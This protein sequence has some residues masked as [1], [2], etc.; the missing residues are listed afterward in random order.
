MDFL[1][2][3]AHLD[4]KVIEVTME[5]LDCLVDLVLKASLD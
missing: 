5:Y 2:L 4:K 3:L 1:D